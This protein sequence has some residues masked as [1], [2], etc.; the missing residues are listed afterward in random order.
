MTLRKS[1]GQF[2]GLARALDHVGDRWTLLVVRDLLAG[3]MTF[4]DLQRSLGEVSPPVLV[5][6]LRALVNDGL[7][8]RSGGPQRSK[9]V[10]YELTEVGRALEPAVHALVR[11]GTQFMVE[12]PG[13]DRVD[14]RWG[15]VALRALLA[16]VSP[17][18][19]TGSTQRRAAL[20]RPLVVHLDV[21]GH[22]LSITDDGRRRDVVSGHVGRGEALLSCTLPDLLAVA[23]GTRPAVH[24]GTRGAGS[25]DLLTE[26]LTPTPDVVE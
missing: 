7:V 18:H 8:A 3:P 13:Q 9:H 19:T 23:S 14:P 2:C 5:D 17:R 16:G 11:W 26:A 4:R 15:V 20:D 22:P 1:Y 21:E 6:R 24:L 10:T 25:L 12:G